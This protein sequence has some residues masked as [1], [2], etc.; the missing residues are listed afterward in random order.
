MEFYLTYEGPLPSNGGPNDKHHI[1]KALHPQLKELWRRTPFLAGTS[2][3]PEAI[4]SGRAGLEVHTIEDLARRFTAH[5]FRWV[6]LV[7]ENM[8]LLCE[9]DVL[10]LRFGNPGSV[11]A[12]G[13]LDNRLKTLFDAVQVPTQQSELGGNSPA[14]DEDPF[15]CVLE[16][17]KLITRVSATTAPLL[18]PYTTIRQ[19]HAKI[20]MEVMVRPYQMHLGN[21]GFG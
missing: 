1:R 7:T 2:D 10:F 17:D 9:I 4:V 13:D 21:I 3:V 6:P 16:N 20:V 18:E 8:S 19:T 5:G 11:V 12:A 14:A 15:F